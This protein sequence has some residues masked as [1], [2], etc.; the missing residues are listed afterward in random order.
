M[1]HFVGVGKDTTYLLSG[2]KKPLGRKNRDGKHMAPIFAE[3]PEIWICRAG[4]PGLRGERDW[5]A[6][7]EEDNNKKGSTRGNV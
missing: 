1:E 4:A 3:P 7:L 6:S 2:G 5:R